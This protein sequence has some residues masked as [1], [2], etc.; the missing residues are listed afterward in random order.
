ML[1]LN[2]TVARAYSRTMTYLIAYSA[3]VSSVVGKRI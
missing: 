1:D 3:L 2:C